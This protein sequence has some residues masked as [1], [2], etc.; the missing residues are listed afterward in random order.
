[1]GLMQQ[2]LADWGLPATDPNPE[3]MEWMGMPVATDQMTGMAS[4]AEL[5][6]LTGARGRDADALF[7]PLM[8][9]HHRGGV[10]MATYAA[11]HAESEFVRSLATRMARNQRIE[12]NELEQARARAGLPESPPGYEPAQV[13][14]SAPADPPDHH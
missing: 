4:E 6:A 7:V 10:H 12:V 9:D 5:T 3:A 11:T 8:Q 2:Q 1:M 14:A 13:P